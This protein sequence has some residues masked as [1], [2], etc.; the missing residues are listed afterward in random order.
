MKQSNN[1]AEQNWQTFYDL[2]LTQRENFDKFYKKQVPYFVQDANAFLSGLSEDEKSE[3]YNGFSQGQFTKSKSDYYKYVQGEVDRYIQGQW[4]KKLHDLWFEKTK[5]KDPV[6]WSEKFETPILCMFDDTDRAVAR[7]MF[8]T[9]MSANPAD[10]DAQAA[11]DY[12]EQADFYD[13]LSDETIRDECFR[14]RIIG[15]YSV[16]LQDVAAVRRNL[17]ENLVHDR[18]YDWLNNLS[19]Q[20]QLKKMADKQYKLTGSDRAMQVIDQMDADQLRSYLREKIQDDVEFGM[21][22]LKGE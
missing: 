10:T 22:I 15:N 4:K 6:A 2:L 16:L 17:V 20:N 3:L 19:V 14:L 7:K 1:L 21:Q 8:Q 5:T 13:R 18:P 12:L 9:V 11:L